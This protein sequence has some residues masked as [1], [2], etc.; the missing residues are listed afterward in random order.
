MGQHSLDLPGKLL[1]G[2]MR[3]IVPFGLHEMHM[4]I[5]EARQ[6]YAA[7]AGQRGRSF[8][9]MRVLADCGNDSI[10]NHDSHTVTRWCLG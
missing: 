2:L 8:G 6:N 4:R 10:T 5:P 9:D 7:I 3:R 1:R